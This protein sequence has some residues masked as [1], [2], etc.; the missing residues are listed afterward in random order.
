M[1]SLSHSGVVRLARRREYVLFPYATPKGEECPAQY[2]ETQW[3]ITG[4]L[5]VALIDPSG[6]LDFKSSGRYEEDQGLGANTGAPFTLSKEQTRSIM[7]A[8]Q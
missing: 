2:G 8:N 1:D 5:G 7:S 4:E 3:T 6:S